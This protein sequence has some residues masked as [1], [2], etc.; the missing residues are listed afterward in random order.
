MA[1][2]SCVRHVSH[3]PRKIACTVQQYY[4]TKRSVLSLSPAP[5]PH[6]GLGPRRRA[7]EMALSNLS[8]DA[9]GIILGQLCST[10]E[11]R[12]AMY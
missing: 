7:A 9:Q 10:L 3:S 5:A 6:S 2:L 11:P 12:L 4:R 1:L 8:G